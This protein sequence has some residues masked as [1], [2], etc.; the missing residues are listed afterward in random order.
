MRQFRDCTSNHGTPLL[1]DLRRLRPPSTTRV[2]D[3]FCYV[4]LRPQ[5]LCR[6]SGAGAA[7]KICLHYMG[8]LSNLC[9]RR[10]LLS[11]TSKT[12]LFGLGDPAAGERKT[13]KSDGNGD[14]CARSPERPGQFELTRWGVA[15]LVFAATT[16][17]CM[18][19]ARVG[20]SQVFLVPC[21]LIVTEQK[22]KKIGDVLP[23][24]SVERKES[25]GT[26]HFAGLEPD[27]VP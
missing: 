24:S 20:S 12:E 1:L 21:G 23:V 19:R 16:M 4:C 9:V 22:K 17:P 13:E 8:C 14:E 2:L 6:K 5:K 3:G 7:L 10:R 26:Q 11:P 18:Q 27:A 15:N 25:T